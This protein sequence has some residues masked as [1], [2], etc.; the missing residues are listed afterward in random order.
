MD[1]I[2]LLLICGYDEA[3]QEFASYLT[4]P[5][6]LTDLIDLS[7]C[8]PKNGHNQFFSFGGHNID[9]EFATNTRDGKEIPTD[10]LSTPYD[11]SG[12]QRGYCYILINFFTIGTFKEMQRFRNIFHKLKFEVIFRKNLNK[13]EII[14]DLTSISK[15]VPNEHKAFIF[16]YLGHGNENNFIHGFDSNH[17]NTDLEINQLL[18][19]FIGKNCPQLKRKPKIFFFNCCRGGE[20]LFSFN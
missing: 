18:N 8:D 11:L 6:D 15:E 16:M 10:S 1:F 7:R 13:E 19:L 9:E 5:K 17:G 12:D 4:P 3:A 2:N 14:D 20:T